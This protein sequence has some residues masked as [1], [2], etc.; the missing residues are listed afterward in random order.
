MRDPR[1]E[2][3]ASRE[4]VR[5]AAEAVKARAAKAALAVLQSDDGRELFE[6]LAKKYHLRG[7]AFLSPQIHAP[8][9]PYAAATRDG[10]KSILNHVYD[11]ARALDSEIRIP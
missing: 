1:Q 5:E 4:A 8:C 3:E 11:L 10:E 9:C 2:H 7:R 6:Y